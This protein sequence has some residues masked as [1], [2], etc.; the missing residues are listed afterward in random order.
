MGYDQKEYTIEQQLMVRY[1]EKMKNKAEFD[2]VIV[3]TNHNN[4]F[5][6]RTTLMRSIGVHLI[7]TRF[8]NVCFLQQQ[9]NIY[10]DCAVQTGVE[11]K[12]QMREYASSFFDYIS[13][14]L[15]F[16][17]LSLFFSLSLS[18]CSILFWNLRERLFFLFSSYP[19][20]RQKKRFIEN[21]LLLVFCL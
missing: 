2:D 17:F 21:C 15:S 5:S 11:E 3:H 4:F 6:I 12:R 14:Y 7:T 8:T 16:F 1:L 13:L 9:S 18:L 20:E 19:R 10:L